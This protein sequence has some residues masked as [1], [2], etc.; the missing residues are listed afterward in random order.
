M[1]LLTVVMTASMYNPNAIVASLG[2]KDYYIREWAS[3]S[4]EV[5]NNAKFP[6]ETSYWPLNDDFWKYLKIIRAQT[7]D[8]EV[9]TRLNYAF[10][11]RLIDNY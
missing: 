7:N 1:W 3:W 9:W 6:Y 8:L 2:S 10:R 5:I 11:W 4:L